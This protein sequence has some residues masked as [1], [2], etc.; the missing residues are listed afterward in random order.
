MNTPFIFTEIYKCAPVGR[1]ML[2][3]YLKHHN[4]PINV[5]I[6]AE[7]IPELGSLQSHPN[8]MLWGMTEEIKNLYKKGHA[9]TAA[10]FAQV[11]KDIPTESFIHIDS[12]VV[13]KRESISLITDAFEAGFDLVGS[14]RCYKNNPGK[15]PMPADIRDSIST[16]FYGF[17]KNIFPINHYTR[18][19]LARL[20]EGHLL[21]LNHP[22][23][24][25]GDPVF[26]HAVYNGAVTYYIPPFLIGGQNKQG[27]KPSEEFKSNLHLDMGLHLAHFGGVGSGFSACAG[28]VNPEE[29]YKQWALGRWNL[30]EFIFYNVPDNS[31][32][33][34]PMHN[35]VYDDAGRWINGNPDPEII[36]EVKHDL[37]KVGLTRIN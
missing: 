25:F 3:S 9:G 2:E 24:D 23:L 19:N 22:I 26:F 34:R 16:Y 15:V 8:V 14:R 5:F 32:A 29:Q 7:S 12:D 18:E 33:S 20:W 37:L 1:I 4:I 21:D 27:I 10:V 17:K 36:E 28:A 30:F 6:D 13:F 35:T 31:I 11:C